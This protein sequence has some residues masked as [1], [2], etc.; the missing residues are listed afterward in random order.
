MDRHPLLDFTVPEKA[1]RACDPHP[2]ASASVVAT[3]CVGL[4]G[5]PRKAADAVVAK[6]QQTASLQL[7]QSFHLHGRSS[8]SLTTLQASDIMLLFP[9]S[10]VLVTMRPTGCVWPLVIGITPRRLI[11]RVVLQRVTHVPRDYIVLQEMAVPDK[12]GCDVVA[13]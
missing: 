3:G 8:L 12:A 7:G 4:S 6:L 13:Q 9:S 2:P 5:A 11:S 1:V 10:T